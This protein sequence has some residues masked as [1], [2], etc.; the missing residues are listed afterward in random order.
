MQSFET[1]KIKLLLTG[2][3]FHNVFKCRQ[4]TDYTTFHKKCHEFLTTVAV[5]LYFLQRLVKPNPTSR[6]HN[7]YTAL[8]LASF[9]KFA[10]CKKNI[11][12]I[13]DAPLTGKLYGSNTYHHRNLKLSKILP[14]D[15][16]FMI[17]YQRMSYHLL[18]IYVTSTFLE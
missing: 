16:N 18:E 4:L 17:Y 13:K 6:H 12:A 15:H 7:H 9:Y 8:Y 1:V 14:N 11:T 3:N 10:F 5:I 2:I